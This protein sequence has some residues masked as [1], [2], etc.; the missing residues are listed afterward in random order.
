[1][2][3]RMILVAAAGIAAFSTL[4]STAE[5]HG[6]GFGFG[7]GGNDRFWSGIKPSF[8]PSYEEETYRRAR[9]PRYVEPRYIEPRHV[10]K[11]HV[12]PATV[13]IKFADGKGRMFDLPS[14][15]WFDGK[16]QCFTGDKPFGFKSGSWFYGNA[17]WSEVNGVWQTTAADGPVAAD[18]RKV[19]AI[20]SKLAE[21]ESKPA[22]K[23]NQERTGKT[24]TTVPK[25]TARL[26]D[27]ELKT[28]EK[29]PGDRP[30]ASAAPA[31]CKKY[32]PSV[33][34]VLTVPCTQ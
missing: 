24:E 33:G 34:E 10:E 3:K 19:P 31:E 28:A 5:A 4:A 18:C 29:Q 8:G 12:P 23:Q 9:R 30:E 21:I 20:A 27:P 13:S 7:F 22:A 2:N 1:M 32:F 6:R 25:S 14:Q 15:V 17:R 16:G 11:K 26:P